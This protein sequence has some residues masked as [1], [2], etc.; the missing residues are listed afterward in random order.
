MF[1]NWINSLGVK[2]RVNH[3]FSDLCDGI[4]MLQ[5]DRSMSKLVVIF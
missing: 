3:L 5:V 4:I 2:P 1:C